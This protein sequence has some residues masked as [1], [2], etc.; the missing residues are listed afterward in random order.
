MPG[1]GT[2]QEGNAVRPFFSPARRQTECQSP[3]RGGRQ[4][5]QRVAGGGRASAPGAAGACGAP[6]APGPPIPLFQWASSFLHSVLPWN[7][8]S[9]CLDVWVRRKL[10]APTR[11]WPLARSSSWLQAIGSSATV[12][13]RQ[14]A[15]GWTFLC[16]RGITTF[17][18]DW[19]RFARHHASMGNY[20]GWGAREAEWMDRRHGASWLMC[21]RFLATRQQQ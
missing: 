15:G 14:A 7:C 2:W 1:G 18:S 16:A 5:L 13:S 19:A 9:L 8:R 10:P 4:Q 3:L 12:G 6:R 21:A 17:G 20:E 11:R